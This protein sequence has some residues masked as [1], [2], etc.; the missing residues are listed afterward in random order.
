MLWFLW[1][2]M[3][4]SVQGQMPWFISEGR[5]PALCLR[6]AA[7]FLVWEEIP[8][9]LR[10]DTLLSVWENALVP[11]WGETLWSFS[12]K[13]CPGLCPRGEAMVLVWGET[14]WSLSE[15]R[16]LV[17]LN[18]IRLVSVKGRHTDLFMRGGPW[19]LSLGK[20]SSFWFLFCF[21]S[22]LFI[23]YCQHGVF[24]A[25]LG[26]SLVAMSRGYSLLLCCSAWASRCGDGFSLWWRLLIAEHQ[27]WV[28]GFSS[29]S[30][31][32]LECRL[33]SVVHRLRSSSIWDL[34]GPGIEPMTPA[35]ADSFLTT[36]PA[37]KP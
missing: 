20:C 17:F 5:R 6:I 18:E 23:Y 28:T 14:L 1:E 25:V 27:L 2:E 22:D 15:G 30:L 21:L 19:S 35:L 32:A 9:S 24:T 36:R 3:P 4:V 11:F 10:M 31:R 26:L 13:S 12:E 7:F 8:W 29:C 16:A 33:S 37:G 34:P